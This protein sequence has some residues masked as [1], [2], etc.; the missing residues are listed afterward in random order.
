MWLVH[1]FIQSRYRPRLL[2]HPRQRGRGRLLGIPRGGTKKLAYAL[3]RG[4]AGLAGGLYAHHDRLSRAGE[5]RPAALDRG[6]GDDRRRRARAPWPGRCLVGDVFTF[7]PEKLQ[8][9]AQYQFIVYGLILAFSLIVLP[10]GLGRLL[11]LPPRFIE[12]RALS[13]RR[14]PDGRGDPD[15]CGRPEAGSSWTASP[16]ASAD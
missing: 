15:R 14:R 7:L 2:R 6:A 13:Q 12:P 5:L 8:V 1:N 11:L 9:F 3:G 16:C 10:R 4:L